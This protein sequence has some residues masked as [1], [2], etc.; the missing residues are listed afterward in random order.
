MANHPEYPRK[1]WI[2]EISDGKRPGKVGR[3]ELRA[4]HPKPG[5]LISE[6]ATYEDALDAQSRY[7][8]EDKH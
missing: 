2:E 5:S 6:H 8:D 1:A 4:D 3:Y 7:L